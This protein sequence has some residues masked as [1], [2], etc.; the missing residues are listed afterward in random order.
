MSD[1]PKTDFITEVFSKASEVAREVVTDIRQEVVERPW[2]GRVVDLAEDAWRVSNSPVVVALQVALTPTELAPP[3]LDEM[4]PCLDALCAQIDQ[5][6]GSSPEP[7]PSHDHQQD[8][9]R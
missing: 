9:D 7:A 6:R 3:E 8:L 4:R 1:K 2:L 5:E